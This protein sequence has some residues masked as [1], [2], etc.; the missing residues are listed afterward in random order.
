MKYLNYILLL[1]SLIIPQAY[2]QQPTENW[3]IA[4]R[5]D[6]NKRPTTYLTYTNIGYYKTRTSNTVPCI[7]MLMIENNMSASFSVVKPNGHLLTGSTA[8][9]TALEPT[10]NG[11]VQHTYKNNNIFLEDKLYINRDLLIKMLSAQNK[12]MFYTK[13]DEDIV[14]S[15]IIVEIDFSKM[16]AYVTLNNFL[17]Y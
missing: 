2:S 13:C 8:D 14:V 1:L 15:D 17:N 3:K 11:V 4:V 7:V 6:I 9:I 16:P 10:E 12:W 5:H